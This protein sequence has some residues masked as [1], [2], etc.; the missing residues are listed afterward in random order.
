MGG[1]I[2]YSGQCTVHCVHLYRCDHEHDTG[3][4]CSRDQH[5]SLHLLATLSPHLLNTI[6]IYSS[7]II[8]ISP[9]SPLFSCD[10]SG[11]RPALRTWHW[12]QLLH[13]TVYRQY[14]DSCVTVE[15]GADQCSEYQHK[16]CPCRSIASPV[17]VISTHTQTQQ[18]LC[19]GS[20]RHHG[21]LS[22]VEE[23]FTEAVDC[24]NIRE[25]FERSFRETVWTVLQCSHIDKIIINNNMSTPDLQY[26]SD[27]YHEDE[28][29]L[30]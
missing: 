6:T 13:L 20:W 19:R 9:V 7:T 3:Q 10:L 21:H 26:E 11:W 22:E 8:F 15:C 25:T 17:T 28:Y 29:D 5:C 23:W 2:L 18:H 30:R 24:D 12:Q 27:E 1:L 16:C 4:Q 14:S